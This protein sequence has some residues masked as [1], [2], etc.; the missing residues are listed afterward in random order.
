MVRATFFQ[1][2]GVDEG[3][4]G[5]QCRIRQAVGSILIQPPDVCNIMLMLPHIPC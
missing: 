2:D 1:T 3:M 4:T 5:L